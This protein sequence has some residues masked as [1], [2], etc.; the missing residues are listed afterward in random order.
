MTEPR[1]IIKWFVNYGS[2]IALFVSAGFWVDSR[3]MHRDSSDFR[4][5]E[6]QMM[7]LEGHM[8]D[9][10]RWVSA[11]NAV[12]HD[13]QLQYDMD[14]EQYKLLQKERNRILGIGEMQ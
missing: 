6:T 8:R 4:H 13:E 2:L 11:G 10:H 9:H 12:N 7:I 5:V 1:V 3:Y 14:K